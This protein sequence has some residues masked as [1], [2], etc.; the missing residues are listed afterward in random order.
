MSKW[1]SK[2][3]FNILDIF[4]DSN[5]GQT[6]KNPKKA[7]PAAKKTPKPKRAKRKNVY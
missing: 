7:K 1:L 4:V 6:K 3:K 2:K 5:M